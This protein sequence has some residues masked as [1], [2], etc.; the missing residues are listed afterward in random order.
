MKKLLSVLLVFGLAVGFGVC[1]TVSASAA[2]YAE[3]LAA[4]NARQAAKTK[5]DDLLTGGYYDYPGF[6][7]GFAL[8]L[9]EQH[10]IS[11]SSDAAYSA[12][13]SVWIDYAEAVKDYDL[14]SDMYINFLL[15]DADA[16]TSTYNLII[17]NYASA[18]LSQGYVDTINEGYKASFAAM[19]AHID[20][21]AQNRG[22]TSA[23]KNALLAET[24]AGLNAA[25]IPSSAYLSQQRRMEFGVATAFAEGT[26]QSKM[27]AAADSAIQK[28]YPTTTYTLTL[29]A[30]GGSVTPNTVTQAAGTTYALPTPDRS[31][32]TFNGWT[33][34]GGG[35]LNGSTYTFGTSNGTVTAQWT[36]DVTSY[37]V[38]V[39][40]GSGGGSYA[41]NATVTI[42]AN[43]APSGKVFDKWTT[44]DGVN[45]ANAS[46]TATTFTMPAK[47]VTVTATYKDT[48]RGIFGTNDKW[49]GE[50][51][52]YILFFFAFGFIWMWFV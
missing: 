44:P 35:S 14:Y 41:A 47:N 13:I 23:Q 31:G 28:L 11:P 6:T 16:L 8:D 51:W 3:Y 24:I 36:A 25:L 34:S 40:S 52:H 4:N 27:I 10:V 29:N 7:S 49:Y 26:L 5:M 33:L 9:H 38:T 18:K 30:N 22:L 2:G 37:N 45:F 42:T 12:Y 32:F 15:W 19:T 43:E 21:F 20:Q 50:W 39:N 1:G 48:P 17:A 46:A